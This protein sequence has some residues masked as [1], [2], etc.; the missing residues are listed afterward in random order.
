MSHACTLILA[1]VASLVWEIWPFFA[2]LQKRPKFPFEPWTIVHGGQKVELAQKIHASRGRR[3]MHAQ[4]VWWVWL[5][6]FRKF[7][8]LS[9][10]PFGAW[11]IVRCGHDLHAL[12]V[13]HLD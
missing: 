2:C 1:G 4:Q 12:H 10:V 13:I 9:N 3:E 6:W 8:F 5:C 11:T 7:W